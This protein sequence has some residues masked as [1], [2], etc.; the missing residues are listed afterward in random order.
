MADAAR[1]QAAQEDT[2]E[3]PR[4]RIDL[5]ARFG[6]FRAAN[7]RT[8]RTA[9]ADGDPGAAGTGPEDDATAATDGGDA[10]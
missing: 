4:P 1:P 6:E 5:G 8:D 7:R 9:P 2:A 10:G 3:V